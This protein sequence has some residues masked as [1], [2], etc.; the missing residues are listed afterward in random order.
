MYMSG[1]NIQFYNVLSIIN[2]N[3]NSNIKALISQVKVATKKLKMQERNSTDQ[4]N[5]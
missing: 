1:T 5:A 4:E 2:T 3:P